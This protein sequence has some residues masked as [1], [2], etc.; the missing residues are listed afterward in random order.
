MRI[1]IMDK[2]KVGILTVLTDTNALAL[3]VGNGTHRGKDLVSVPQSIR[4]NV[5]QFFEAREPAPLEFVV[6]GGVTAIIVWMEEQKG[7]GASEFPA[8][9][10]AW[11]DDWEVFRVSHAG[12]ER[13]G[14]SRLV[15][16]LTEIARQI[17]E[18]APL[19]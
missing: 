16:L 18:A 3:A 12:D 8:K 14:Y 15:G 13:Q 5:P 10:Q 11:L 17:D 9:L 4:A 6:C 1:N 19:N 7:P 2:M